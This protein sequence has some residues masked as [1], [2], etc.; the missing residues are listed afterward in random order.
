MIRKC[1][2]FS[3]HTGKHLTEYKMPLN[4][5][6]KTWSLLDLERRKPALQSFSNPSLCFCS[7]VN[8]T[9]FF[10]KHF[11]WKKVT[12]HTFFIVHVS[13]RHRCQP[14]V[15]RPARKD[16]RCNDR[17]K[18][19]FKSSRYFLDGTFSRRDVWMYRRPPNYGSALA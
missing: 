1:P 9:F 11:H 16:L 15:Q 12:E 8:L 6:T 7:S 5:P 10:H 17:P 2:C 19:Q 14:L 13:D 3:V 18:H 4:I